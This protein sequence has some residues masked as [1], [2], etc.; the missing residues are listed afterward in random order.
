MQ[1]L[2]SSSVAM[3][4]LLVLVACAGCCGEC[5]DGTDALSR[6][7]GT[8]AWGELPEELRLVVNGTLPSFLTGQYF[9][10]SASAFSI[11]GGGRATAVASA[12]AGQELARGSGHKGGEANKSL[13]GDKFSLIAL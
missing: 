10:A 9:L 3:G 11:P 7:W 6:A 12:V 5:D 4:G 8:S 1:W 13:E 2:N